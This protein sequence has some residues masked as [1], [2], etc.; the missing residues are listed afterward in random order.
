MGDDE[1][2]EWAENLLDGLIE[3]IDALSY[4]TPL[5]SLLEK[6]VLMEDIPAL[7]RLYANK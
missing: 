4:F 5:V 7:R 2:I 1:L 3:K 6:A